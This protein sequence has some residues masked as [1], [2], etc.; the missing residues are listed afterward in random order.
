VLETCLQNHSAASSAQVVLLADFKNAFGKVWFKDVLRCFQ[1]ALKVYLGLMEG[2]WRTIG[3]TVTRKTT[4][5][6]EARI[7]KS[8]KSSVGCAMSDMS[9]CLACQ[10][11][12]LSAQWLRRTRLK[13]RACAGVRWVSCPSL[14]HPSRLVSEVLFYSGSVCQ[15][16]KKNNLSPS[17]M[18]Q[19]S[20]TPATTIQHVQ[21]RS[22]W[23]K[24]HSCTCS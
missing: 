3:S 2:Q 23:S 5:F 20:N 14:R 1:R 21:L 7:W 4:E 9:V 22:K 17:T 18:F 10:A 19:T 15:N 11:W 16:L 12:K 13:Q 8:G 6:I 24:F